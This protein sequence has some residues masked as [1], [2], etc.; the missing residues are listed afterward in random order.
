MRGV[1]VLCAALRGSGGARGRLGGVQEG[2]GGEGDRARE[3]AARVGDGT[4]RAARCALVT[5]A[6]GGDACGGGGQGES[7]GPEAGS[8]GSGVVIITYKYQ[9]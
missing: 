3:G 7:T 6:R 8:G 4:Q 2:G 5:V 1:R 9:N